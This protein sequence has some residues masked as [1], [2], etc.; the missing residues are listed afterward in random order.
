MGVAILDKVGPELRKKGRMSQEAAFS[1]ASASSSCPVRIPSKTKSNLQDEVNRFLFWSWCLQ[2]QRKTNQ[3]GT[4]SPA[5]N[6][7]LGDQRLGLRSEG[8][9]GKKHGL[10]KGVESRS[11][12]TECSRHCSFQ[13]FESV[14]KRSLAIGQDPPTHTHNCTRSFLPRNSGHRNWPG[15]PVSQL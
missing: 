1:N 15:T 6:K 9:P 5:S 2:Q 10:W 8:P 3:Q 13:L 11:G 12:V 7:R 4:V 14:E